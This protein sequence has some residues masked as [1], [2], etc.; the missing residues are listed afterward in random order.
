[1]GADVEQVI[2][3]QRGHAHQLPRGERPRRP[4]RRRHDRRPGRED[5]LIG[6]D[7]TPGNDSLAAP[8]RG[9]PARRS[10]DDA[11]DGGADDDVLSGR[12]GRRRPGRRSRRRRRVRRAG[13]AWTRSRA[14]RRRPPLRRR[15]ASSAG[16]A[17]TASAVGRVP[18]SCAADAGTT[19]ST[20]DRAPTCQRRGG[21]DRHLRTRI[22]P[23]R[24]PVPDGSRTRCP[25]TASATST[26][27]SPTTSRS[28]SA[29]GG[30]RHAHGQGRRGHRGRGPGEDLVDGGPQADHRTPAATSPISSGHATARPT[31]SSAGTAGPR[32]RRS[33]GHRPRV[34]AVD[35]GGRRR[36]RARERP[37]SCDPSRT[38]SNCACPA[39]PG[40]STCARPSRSPCIR[41][42]MRPRGAVGHRANPCGRLPTGDRPAGDLHAAPDVWRPSSDAAPAPR[43]VLPRLPGLCWGSGSAGR[44]DKRRRVRLDISPSRWRQVGGCTGR[45]ARA[46]PKGPPG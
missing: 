40:S 7:N 33:A 22:A 1:M 35:E 38:A 14:D 10:G 28:C 29:A 25:T 32:A 26:T 11:L 41:R 16:T 12:R 3:R 21:Q 39:A 20:A 13:P 46:P 4:R 19:G 8:A 42:S 5:Q 43:H 9:R 45:T 6:G 24:C 17:P 27:T 36:L 37:R 15:A 34:R 18:M 2:R 44:D 30:G 31:W 23:T